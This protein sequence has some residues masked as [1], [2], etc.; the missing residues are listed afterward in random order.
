MGFSWETNKMTPLLKK[1]KNTQVALEIFS[2][3]AK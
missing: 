1:N 2:S 3:E